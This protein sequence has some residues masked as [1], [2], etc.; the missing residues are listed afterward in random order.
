MKPTRS[1]GHGVKI[2]LSAQYAIPNVRISAIPNSNQKIL[3]IRQNIRDRIG[4]RRDYSQV[5][6][7][8]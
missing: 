4:V 2:R 8:A 1:S 7:R 5:K 6:D 3:P